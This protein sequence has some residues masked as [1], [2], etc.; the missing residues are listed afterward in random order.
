MKFERNLGTVD[1]VLRT[2][3]S[4]AMIY[5]GLID[6][7]LITDHLAGVILGVLGVANLVMVAASYCPLYALIGI[8][9]IS[10]RVDSTT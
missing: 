1:R 3:I 10:R 8:S 9:T 7:Q 2:G 6:N 5:L 4:A